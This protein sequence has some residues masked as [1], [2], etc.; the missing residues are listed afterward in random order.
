[1]GQDAAALEERL[2]LDGGFVVTRSGQRMSPKGR[3]RVLRLSIPLPETCRSW[4]PAGQL[5]FAYVRVRPI[6]VAD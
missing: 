2:E 6:P 1:M 4:R 5:P 3:L